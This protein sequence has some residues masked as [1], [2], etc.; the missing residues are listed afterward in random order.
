MRPIETNQKTEQRMKNV[1]KKNR[2]GR[3]N[4][5]E[6]QAAKNNYWRE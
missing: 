2:G 6:S 1:L 5:E 4:M 3:K